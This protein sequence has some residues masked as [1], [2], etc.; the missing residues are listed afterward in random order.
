MQ[1]YK[2]HI[3][4]RVKCINDT[5]EIKRVGP[6]FEIIKVP[7]LEIEKVYTVMGIIP[8]NEKIGLVFGRWEGNTFFSKRVIYNAERFISVA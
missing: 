3:G 2:F 1:N 4:Q 5:L 8:K 6:A 7:G